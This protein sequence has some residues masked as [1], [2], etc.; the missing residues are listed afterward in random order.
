MSDNKE[1]AINHTTYHLAQVFHTEINEDS[2]LINARV[3][4]LTR[5]NFPMIS[6]AKGYE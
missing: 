5:Q 3:N 1:N 2:R 4:A 6:L